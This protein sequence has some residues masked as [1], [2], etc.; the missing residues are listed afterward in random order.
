M[1]I[2]ICVVIRHCIYDHEAV[3]PEVRQRREFNSAF[4]RDR[5]G[6]H[7]DSHEDNNSSGIFH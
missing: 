3:V 1:E 5:P 7:E 6:L 2:E 4:W